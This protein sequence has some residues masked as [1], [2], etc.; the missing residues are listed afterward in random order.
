MEINIGS[1][2]IRNT[3]GVLNV[4]GKDQISLEVREDGQLLVTMDIY[5]DAGKHTSRL[6]RNAW[7][8]NKGDRFWV[9]TN[10]SDL[11]LTDSSTGEIVV[12]VRVIDRGHLEVLEGRFYTHKGHLLEIT[13]EYWRVAGIITMSGNTID[14]CDGAVGIS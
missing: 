6:L 9:T 14:G 1:N 10:P 4:E 2:I 13:P 3:N 8:F 12:R 5:D 11:S 7:T